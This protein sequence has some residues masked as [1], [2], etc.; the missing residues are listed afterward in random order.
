LVT[1][2]S[3]VSFGLIEKSGVHLGILIGVGAIVLVF[4]FLPI[5]KRLRQS[6]KQIVLVSFLFLILAESAVIIFNPLDSLIP[7]NLF[8]KLNI[9]KPIPA[10]RECGLTPEKVRQIATFFNGKV[11]LSHVKIYYKKISGRFSATT[12]GNSIY[13]S[14][15]LPCLTPEILVHELTHVWQYQAGI[16]IG[17]K[18]ISYWIYYYWKYF[19]DLNSL[20]EYGSLAGLMTAQDAG[21]TL[22]SF[23][24]EQQA[25][26][27]TNFYSYH[28]ICE[29]FP[30]LPETDVYK[31]YK[32]FYATEFG[33]IEP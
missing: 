20:Y 17:P 7:E 5:P 14:S 24:I 4:R 15:S 1:L 3:V 28:T 29:L 30:N 33:D 27:I 6:K 26:I 16:G 8:I 25:E 22:R 10:D 11:D 18:W 13:I 23:G 9:L 21:K 32:Y 12:W 19:T 31:I 2:A